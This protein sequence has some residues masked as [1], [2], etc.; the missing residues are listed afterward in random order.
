M[1]RSSLIVWYSVLL[2][3]IWAVSYFED[4]GTA[5]VTAVSALVIWIPDHLIGIV[6]LIVALLAGIGVVRGEGRIP[7]LLMLPQQFIMFLCAGGA[8]Q[9]MWLGQF[10]D[11][12]QRSHWFLAA[13][14]SPAVLAAFLHMIAVVRIWKQQKK[15]DL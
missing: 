13:D 3:L 6:L 4:Y 8:L 7:A 1:W 12:V 2:H 5:S 14:Q 15:E 9:A 11:G 10:A